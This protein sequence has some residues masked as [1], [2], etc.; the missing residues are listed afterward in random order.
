MGRAARFRWDPVFVIISCKISCRVHM[1]TKL[2]QLSEMPPRLTRD[3]GWSCWEFSIWMQCPGL[4]HLAGW[5]LLLSS[6]EN[7]VVN[8][9]FSLINIKISLSK[10]I[11]D[12]NIQYPW[13]IYKVLKFQVNLN[14]FF[15]SGK[16]YP[17][18]PQRRRLRYVPGEGSGHINRLSIY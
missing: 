4:A 7:I 18:P 15:K 8:K 3:L 6:G 14:I 13:R 17:T 9:V 5:V 12:L 10:E 11:I 1:R 2:G 16:N